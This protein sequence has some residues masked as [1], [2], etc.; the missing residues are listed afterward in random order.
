MLTGELHTRS[1]PLDLEVRDT[2]DG[3]SVVGLV[4]PYGQPADIIEVRDGRP[5]RYRE[6]FVPGAFDRAMRVPH[7][8]ALMYG[9]TDAFDQR[10][11]YAVRFEDSQE[12]LLATFRLDRSRADHARD[13]LSSSHASLSVGFLSLVPRPLTER[14]GQL[15]TRESVH[16][17]HVAAV[18]EPAYAGA[19]VLAVRAA[20]VDEG[21]PTANEAAHALRQTRQAELFARMDRLLTRG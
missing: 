15:V 16:L 9:H 3:V 14:E 11:G 19:R 5:I 18:E 1:F 17:G 13:V 10:L 2:T 21:E 12:G 7:R 8:V 20:D 4:V 6:Q